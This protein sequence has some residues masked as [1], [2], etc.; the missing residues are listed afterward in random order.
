MRLFRRS[1]SS[2]INDDR[3]D[4]LALSHGKSPVIDFRTKWSNFNLGLTHRRTPAHPQRPE[5]NKSMQ[6]HLPK[7]TNIDAHKQDLQQMPEPSERDT[8]KVLA[9]I[10]YRPLYTMKE[11][12]AHCHE[13]YRPNWGRSASASR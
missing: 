2:L 10:N 13:F 7:L 4:V 8:V 5:G 3:S 9:I 11:F 1:G 6:I 12:A